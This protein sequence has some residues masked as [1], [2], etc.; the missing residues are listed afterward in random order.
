MRKRV[1]DDRLNEIRK[2]DLLSYFKNYEPDELV[3]NGRGD[4][5][6]KTYS[7]LHMSH[8]LWCWWA[9]EYNGKKIGGNSA[10]DYLIKVKEMS[11]KEAIQYLEELTKSQP[12]KLTQT[13]PKTA[14]KF[15]LPKKAIN[16]EMVL[17]YLNKKR[18]I[19]LEIIQFCINHSLIYETEKD[20]AAVFVGYDSNHIPRFASKRSTTEDWKKDVFGSDKRFSFS[21]SN[22]ESD[23]LHVFESV[24]DLLSFI[25][26]EKRS[27]RAYMN[28]NYLS[29]DGATL[30][31][32]TMTDS[33]IPVALDSF[34]EQHADIKSIHLHLDND[35]AGKETSAII[36]Y[37]LEYQYEIHDEML[38]RYKDVNEAL[39]A[40]VKSKMKSIS[41]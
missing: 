20:H 39:I 18:C 34:L 11:F 40:K 41:R 26:L 23:S 22:Q 13:K 35:R 6:T 15:V 12:P 33:P 38:E 8:G 14:G 25:T 19:D 5:S 9:H 17:K 24:I 3:K 4:Y 10:L 1:S 30:I 2:L 27:G 36:Q 29:L 7:S 32:K 31:G 37:H 16:D 21:I 28:K